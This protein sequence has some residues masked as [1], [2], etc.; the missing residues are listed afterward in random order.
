MQ[1]GYG[2]KMKSYRNCGLQKV[3]ARSF[4][5]NES[6]EKLEALDW[7]NERYS[8]SQTGFSYKFPTWG[9]RRDL[10]LERF[11]FLLSLIPKLQLAVADLS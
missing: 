6:L 8:T 10:Y 5:R 9:S 1:K 3:T 2:K 7:K 4:S 11:L